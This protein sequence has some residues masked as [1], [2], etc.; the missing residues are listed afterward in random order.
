MTLN[1]VDIG[2][3]TDIV[4]QLSCDALTKLHYTDTNNYVLKAIVS[5][6]STLTGAMVTLS[7]TTGRVLSIIT[8]TKK[9]VILRNRSGTELASDCIGE[10]YR[11]DQG[12]EPTRPTSNLRL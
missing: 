3:G 2:S 9:P 12:M 7:G 8:L 10:V 4:Y 1:R 6:T 11:A 5:G